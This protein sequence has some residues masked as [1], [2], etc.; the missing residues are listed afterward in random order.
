MNSHVWTR[1]IYFQEYL[2]SV[3]KSRKSSQIYPEQKKTKKQKNSSRKKKKK[4]EKE[5]NR[6]EKT[7]KK[8]KMNFFS[9]FLTR[10][11]LAPQKANME[12]EINRG[13]N[14]VIYKEKKS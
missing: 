5:K 10:N 3:K 2:Q 8:T 4:S 7:N 14:H 1:F 12:V 13:I 9:C 11:T 6:K